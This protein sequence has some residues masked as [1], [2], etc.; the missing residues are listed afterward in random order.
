MPGSEPGSY[1]RF[2]RRVQWI[3]LALGL[4]GAVSLSF[5]RGIR[6]GA[7]FLIGAV[8]SFSS[9]WGWQKVVDGLGGNPRQRGRIFFVLRL[10]ALVAVAWVIIKY[11]QLNVA[12]AAMGLLVSG[13]AVVV[14]LIYEMIYAS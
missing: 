14:E 7:A 10:I 3:I 8:I 2:I 4:T 5:A 13:A 6:N 1:E 11:L 12:A 9:F